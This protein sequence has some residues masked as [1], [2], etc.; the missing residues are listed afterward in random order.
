MGN[1]CHKKQQKDQFSDI[2]TN[3]GGVLL[4]KTT[5]KSFFKLVKHTQ[6]HFDE[7]NYN[8]VFNISLSLDKKDFN[9]IITSKKIIINPSLKYTHWKEYLIKYLRKQTTKGYQWSSDLSE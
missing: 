7:D 4:D 1:K 8:N 5:Y 3:K 6:R 2:V 9:T